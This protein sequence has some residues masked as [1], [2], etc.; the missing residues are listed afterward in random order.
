MH[1][2]RG[3]ACRSDGLRVQREAEAR[4]GGERGGG[5]P[6]VEECVDGGD[7]RARRQDELK[8]ARSALGVDLLRVDVGGLEG[9]DEVG[10]ELGDAGIRREAARGGPG[11]TG[12]GWGLEAVVRAVAGALEEDEL[13]LEAEE[14]GQAL[15]GTEFLGSLQLGPGTERNDGAVLFPEIT[16]HAKVPW[17]GAALE[18]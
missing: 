2:R 16:I 15:L 4:G 6:R 13:D 18:R 8:L 9:A 11:V 7:G 1:M 3:A 5:V 10:E 14:E 12:G 17:D